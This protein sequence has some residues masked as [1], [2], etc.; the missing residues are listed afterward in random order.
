[1]EHNC[2]VSSDVALAGQIPINHSRGV[3]HFSSMIFFRRDLHLQTT[4]GWLTNHFVARPIVEFAHLCAMK[5]AV[6]NPA[7]SCRGNESNLHRG[8]PVYRFKFSSQSLFYSS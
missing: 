4:G 1:M 2:H 6:M 7:I 3:N 5:M 8:R